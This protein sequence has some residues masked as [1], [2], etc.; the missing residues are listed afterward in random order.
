VYRVRLFEM[1]ARLSGD[2]RHERRSGPPPLASGDRRSRRGW[3]RRSRSRRRRRI[4]AAQSSARASMRPYGGCM[5]WSPRTCA[6][7]LPRLFGE[8]TRC[9][10]NDPGRLR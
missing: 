10:R 3:P 2:P 7:T 8:R 9:T 5:R 1:K 6:A 4:R